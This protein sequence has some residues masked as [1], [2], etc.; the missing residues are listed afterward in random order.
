MIFTGENGSKIFWIMTK[1]V[2]ENANESDD[3]TSKTGTALIG[4]SQLLKLKI[5]YQK[6][7]KK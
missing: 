3:S 6:L 1:T 5:V 2:I 7:K 4:R